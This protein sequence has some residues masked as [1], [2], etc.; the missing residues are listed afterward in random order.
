M[1]E[2]S[3]KTPYELKVLRT[4][5]VRPDPDM[6]GRGGG[7]GGGEVVVKGFLGGRDS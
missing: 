4:K 2:R 1:F 6:R 3:I 5:F 7:G